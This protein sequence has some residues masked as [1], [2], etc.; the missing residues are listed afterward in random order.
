M[1][2]RHEITAGDIVFAL[3]MVVLLLLFLLVLVR[4]AAHICEFVSLIRERTFTSL[5]QPDMRIEWDADGMDGR[6]NEVDINRSHTMIRIRYTIENTKDNE[7][8]A[9]NRS[10]AAYQNG[11]RLDNTI[12]P[13]ATTLESGEHITL[14]LLPHWP[15]AMTEAFRL[16]DVNGLI[17]LQ[18]TCIDHED[19]DEEEP[20]DDADEGND[21][22]TVHGII[23]DPRTGASRRQF[24]GEDPDPSTSG[25]LDHTS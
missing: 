21:D 20:A 3:V 10:L 15:V 11:I 25:P 1:L 23:I 14:G 6:I 5:C 18:W 12:I 4:L 17:I 2:V 13:R 7:Q 22:D 19:D 9:D 16:L 24:R 8:D